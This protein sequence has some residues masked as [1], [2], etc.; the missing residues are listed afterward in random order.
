MIVSTFYFN[1]YPFF[2]VPKWHPLTFVANRKAFE[3]DK[4]TDMEC[5]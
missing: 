3:I 5:T 1:N 2:A 4:Q